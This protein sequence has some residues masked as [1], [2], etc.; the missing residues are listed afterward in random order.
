MESLLAQLFASFFQVG[1]FSVGGGYAAIP[2][3]QS[4]VVDTYH[5][6]TMAEFAD[7]ITIAEMTPG[8]VAINSA[9]FVGIRVSGLLG[10][11][12]CTFACILAPV[13]FSLTLAYVYNKYSSLDA[14]KTVLSCMRPAVVALISAAALSILMLALLGSEDA[15]LSLT[16]LKLVET[17]LF[18]ISL[19]LLRL[20][21]AGPIT[22]IFGS[23]IVGTLLYYLVPSLIR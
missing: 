11:T 14:V 9:T 21:K 17:G 12:L 20:K 4:Q 5:L 8:P 23:G 18:L 13:I 16:N 10:A 15:A 22:V 19:A 6:L 1:L 7:L 3:I 2:L